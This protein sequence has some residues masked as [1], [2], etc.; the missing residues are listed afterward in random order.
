MKNFWQSLGDLLQGRNPALVGAAAGLVLGL[1]LVIFGF[2]K[3]LFILALTALGYYLGH[4][5]FTNREDFRNLLDKI[6][7]PGKFR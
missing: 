3:T 4:R 1:L 5:F 6:L 2:W 7:P